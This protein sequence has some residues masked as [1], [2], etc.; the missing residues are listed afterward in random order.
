MKR[1]LVLVSLLMVPLSC[2]SE[3][4]C[5]P[6]RVVECPCEDGGEG[7][8]TCMDDGSK[9]GECDCGS[10]FGGPFGTTTG[11]Y[12]P[13]WCV[14]HS[15]S[16]GCPAP[17][18]GI[19]VLFHRDG[20]IRMF[21]SVGLQGEADYECFT[22]GA[23]LYLDSRVEL[24]IPGGGVVVTMP[25]DF[26]QQPANLEVQP[27]RGDDETGACLAFGDSFH[28]SELS[29]DLAEILAQNPVLNGYAKLCNAQGAC[30]EMTFTL[31]PG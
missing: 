21:F 3:P 15:L 22:N 23:E 2:D 31:E 17:Q 27:I 9:W 25:D 6:G 29:P 24:S 12:D 28:G 18:L 30:D 7:A 1:G 8:Q 19:D 13:D 20:G 14:D 5:E 16:G 11:G 4:V 10:G 26:I